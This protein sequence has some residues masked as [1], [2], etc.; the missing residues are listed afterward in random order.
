[1]REGRGRAPP[2]ARRAPDDRSRPPRVDPGAGPRRSRRWCRTGTAPARQRKQESPGGGPGLLALTDAA[3][4][5][6]RRLEPPLGSGAGGEKQRRPLHS[7]RGGPDGEPL[8]PRTFGSAFASRPG[9][10]DPAPALVRGSLSP[11]RAT[12]TLPTQVIC[13]TCAAPEQPSMQENRSLGRNEIRRPVAC[14]ARNSCCSLGPPFLPILV[15]SPTNLSG[16][17]HRTRSGADRCDF[18]RTVSGRVCSA[19]HDRPAGARAPPTS[20]ARRNRSSSSC[21]PRRPR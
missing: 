20:P 7:L 10:P 19:G 4:E 16:K 6:Q 2:L 14:T 3:R 8:P 13:R 15:V 11:G 12:M 9:L 17:R 21:V 18:G 1:M 5:T